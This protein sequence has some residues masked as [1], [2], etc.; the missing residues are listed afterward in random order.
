MI[1]IDKTME[2]SNSTSE[3]LLNKE[4]I[5]KEDICKRQFA[6]VDKGW[7]WVV[8]A[9]SFGTFCLMGGTQFASGIVHMILL[10]KYQTSVSLTSV[11]GA[12]HTSLISIGA[13]LS[14]FVLE[15]NSCRVAIVT[16]GCLFFLGYLGTAFAPN[17]ECV[18]FTYGVVAGVGG[19]LGFTASMVVVGYNFQRRRNIAMG[20][21]VAG[22][23]FGITFLAPLIQF[24]Y[25][26]YG[27]FGFFLLISAIYA[28]SIVFGMLAI[29]S[30]L[31]LYTK[32]RRTEQAVAENNKN[33]FSSRC[34]KLKDSLSILTNKELLLLCFGLFNFGLGTY[35]IYLHLPRYIVEKGFTP[36]VAANLVSLSGILTVIGRIL[37]GSIA[38]VK[39]IRDDILYCLPMFILGIMTI[40]YPYI[41]STFVGNLIFAI[42]LGSFYGN[43]YVLTTSVSVKHVGIVN[44]AKAIG[45]QY[46]FAGLGILLGPILAGVIVDNGGTYE[47]S[48]YTA[49]GILSGTASFVSKS[50]PLE[51][52]T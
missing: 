2:K 38:T 44:L 20:I 28:Q 47:D 8:L 14:S 10:E 36:E 46:F 35:L 31:E 49:A 18:I 16:C 27:S 33:G 12:V 9:G 25:K 11:A 6:D 26:E 52:E 39:F 21:A 41:S 23:G 5:H 45:I 13:P 22:V 43:V 24:I 7:A 48:F 30:K 50:K 42:F 34:P 1:E 15:R 40:I 32:A 37:T 4:H 3:S 51:T 19:A 29:P 17:I